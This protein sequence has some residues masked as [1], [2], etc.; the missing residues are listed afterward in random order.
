MIKNIVA[1]LERVRPD[2]SLSDRL[3]A[4]TSWALET[5][6]SKEAGNGELDW[7]AHIKNWAPDPHPLAKLFGK[8]IE[9]GHRVTIIDESRIAKFN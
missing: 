7:E 8:A 3:A 5:C 9:N 6:H 2:L 1:E 4:H